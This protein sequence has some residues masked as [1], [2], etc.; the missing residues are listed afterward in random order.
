MYVVCVYVTEG[1]RGDGCDLASN[2]CKYDLANG[3]LF[4]P[5]WAWVRQV[6]REVSLQSC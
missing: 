2:L 5:R 3:D 4:V 6:R 1:Q